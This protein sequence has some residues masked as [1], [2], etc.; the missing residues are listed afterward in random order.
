MHHAPQDL[1]DFGPSGIEGTGGFARQGIAAGTRVIEYVGE[2]I[3]K[4]ESVTRC[5]KGNAFIFDLNETWDL[6][7]NV[8]WNP[9]RYLN[10]SCRPNC[11]AE[12][13]E[14]SIWIVTTRDVRPG[15]ELT[16]NYGYDLEES[17][18][19][20]EAGEPALIQNPHEATCPECGQPMRF[21]FQFGDF[22]PGVQFGDAGVCYVY[23]CDRH[24]EQCKGFVDTH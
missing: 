21:L 22:V 16:F 11:D 15:E 5:E 13:I 3:T 7:G 2:R 12:Q 8:P 17:M 9:A 4:P 14:D 10:H 23:G 19:A 6:D 20:L 24:P 18:L 1:I